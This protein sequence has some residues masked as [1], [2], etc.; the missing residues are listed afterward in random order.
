MKKPYDGTAGAILLSFGASSRS[1]IVFS[2]VTIRLCVAML[3]S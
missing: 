1:R 3:I 2:D